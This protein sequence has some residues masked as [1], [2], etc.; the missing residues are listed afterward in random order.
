MSLKEWLNRM[1]EKNPRLDFLPKLKSLFKRKPG[2]GGLLG[3]RQPFFGLQPQGE[4]GGPGSHMPPAEQGFVPY[5]NSQPL[6]PPPMSPP[7]QWG[8]PGPPAINWGPPEQW[9]APPGHWGMPPDVPPGGL[10]AFPPDRYPYWGSGPP[11]APPHAS[12]DWGGAP[13]GTWGPGPSGHGPGGP[14]PGGPGSHSLGPPQ[15]PSGT[16]NL[17]KSSKRS[18]AHRSS[19]KRGYEPLWR[20]GGLGSP[21]RNS[22]PGR[23]HSSSNRGER[24]SFA[25]EGEERNIQ[26]QEK[27]SGQLK[28]SNERLS[29]SPLLPDIESQESFH[30]APHKPRS[31]RKRERP[32]AKYPPRT[33]YP[34]P[35][36][37]APH[38]KRKSTLLQRAVPRRANVVKWPKRVGRAN[39]IRRA[40]IM[41]RTNGIGG[42][43][44]IGK[45]HAV[46][47]RAPIGKSKV[48]V[49]KTPRGKK[50][51]HQKTYHHLKD[52]NRR[53]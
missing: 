14:G 30:L 25:R 3:N 45:S 41:G 15:L 49:K 47:R 2:R 40:R 26:A 23:R 22:S 38:L 8:P 44:S 18:R 27:R 16:F 46:G 51:Y 33:K 43:K 31:P 13:P 52:F 12:P 5:S 19:R 28:E 50:T 42:T 21:L 39:P 11:G 17:P 29:V 36:K 7:E 32:I 37:V 24:E 53:R 20:S 34:T 6:P 1:M 4:R 35:R 48:A 10:G 9:G